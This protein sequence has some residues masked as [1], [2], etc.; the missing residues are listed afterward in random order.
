MTTIQGNST[1]QSVS[2]VAFF[3]REKQ[4]QAKPMLLMVRMSTSICGNLKPYLACISLHHQKPHPL[5]S[6]IH[7]HS[8]R[9][10]LPGFS[11]PAA[12]QIS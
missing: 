8:V 9:Y 12:A 4:R 10:E 1:K 11:D 6:E 7:Q 2:V 5:F 3:K